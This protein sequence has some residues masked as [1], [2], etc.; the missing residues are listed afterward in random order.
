MPTTW[1]VHVERPTLTLPSKAPLPCALQGTA[2][3]PGMEAEPVRIRSL[4]NSVIEFCWAE[5]LP[6]SLDELSKVKRSKRV[7]LI[8]ICARGQT[9]PQIGVLGTL[10]LDPMPRVGDFL[11]VHLHTRIG[12]RTLQELLK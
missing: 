8:R 5:R 2:S 11:R 12:T 3:P 6:T 7:V 1:N 9:Q 10:S 4:S